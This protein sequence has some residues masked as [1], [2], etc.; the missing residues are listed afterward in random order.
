MIIFKIATI[1]FKILM[2]N[3]WFIGKDLDAGKDWRQ[4][5]GAAEDE[6]AGYHQLNGYESEQ[7]SG[8]SEGQGSLPYC[9]P[10]DRKE[11]DTT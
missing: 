2:C 9:N 11:S 1:P 10:W 4:E 6:M 7:I 3:L 5:K 8:D